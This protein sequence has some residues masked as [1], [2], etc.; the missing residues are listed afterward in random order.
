MS[1]S[2]SPLPGFESQIIT[3]F[4]GIS[5]FG[6]R[7]FVPLSYRDGP[8]QPQPGIG[9]AP[10]SR[11]PSIRRCRGMFHVRGGPG[12]VGI[13]T[14]ARLRRSAPHSPL[15]SAGPYP[16]CTEAPHTAHLR[17]SPQVRAPRAG[18]G[19]WGGW[20][21]SPMALNGH[22]TPPGRAVPVL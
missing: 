20:Y 11:S 6:F 22:P 8:A 2:V 12:G 21:M 3:L 13:A 17:H 9:Q 15:P 5:R 14:G 18:R 16:E 1:R 4:C 7:G 10:M 19:G